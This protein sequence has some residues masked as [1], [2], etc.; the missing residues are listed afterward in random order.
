M[1]HGSRAL[2]PWP[3]PG[4]VPTSRPCVG[5]MAAFGVLLV[6]GAGCGHDKL[7]A[8]LGD[9][10]GSG[11]SG[12]G[13]GGQTGTGGG[14]PGTGGSPTFPTNCDDIGT[15]PIIPP[16][17]STVLAPKMSTAGTLTDEATLDTKLIQDA[18]NACPAGQ[19]VRLA[20]DGTNDAFLSGPLFMKAGVTLWID[21][22]VT[23]FTSRNPRTFDA[24][25][26]LCGG[27]GTGSSACYALIN[28]RAVPGR[29]HGPGRD[30]RAR[31]R[32]PD[33]RHGHLVVA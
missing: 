33:G 29:G 14:T 23:L 3:L 22:G 2:R 21:A 11:G 30:R 6:L 18:I 13:T 7:A 4:F 16:A 12:T 19:S 25:A 32:A 20:T 15:E 27:N 10:T 9:G 1:T 5:G 26:G 8:A 24:K 17:C 28:V 31:R